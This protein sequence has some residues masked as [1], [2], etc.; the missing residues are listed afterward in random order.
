MRW[1]CCAR[2][3]TILLVA[4]ASPALMPLASRFATGQEKAQRPTTGEV[5][6]VKADDPIQAID[7]EYKR[8][9]VELGR[10]RLEQLGR[11]AARQ[12]PAEAAVTYERLFRLAI[13]DDLFRDAESA[14]AS[15]IEQGTPSAA[16]IALAH[17]V[18]IIAETDRGAFD[19][20]LR[21]LA[22]GRY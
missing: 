9:V 7:D 2:N 18:K 11:L 5:R 16:T 21:K 13:A 22:P 14:A 3:V 12:N 4:I 15:V 1:A 17:L 8:Q 6:S 19:Q 20:S 10:R